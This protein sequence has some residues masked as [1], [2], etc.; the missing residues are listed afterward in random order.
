VPGKRLP[1]PVGLGEV[2]FEQA[3]FAFV[4]H[5]EREVGG[6]E[7]RCRLRSGLRAEKDGEGIRLHGLDEDGSVGNL[8][9]LWRV[10]VTPDDNEMLVGFRAFP[11]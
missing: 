7:T 10:H 1:V 6:D 2:P 5:Y 9:E 4:F 8:V 3:A 11:P